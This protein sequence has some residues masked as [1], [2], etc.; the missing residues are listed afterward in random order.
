MSRGYT[1]CGATISADGRYR[2]KLWRRWSVDHDCPSWVPAFVMLN[3]STADGDRDDPTIRRCV[4]FARGW[5]YKGVDI[6]NLFA[7]RATDP[8]DLARA[9]DIVGPENGKYLR[10]IFGRQVIVAAWGAH[11]VARDRAQRLVAAASPMA[12]LSCLGVTASGAPR[13]PLYVRADA[14]P[15]PYP[16]V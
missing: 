8:S 7:Y 11:P 15:V 1:E 4:G 9:R 2:Y 6:Y 12:C 3:P 5:G 14:K 10:E 16:G 13:H